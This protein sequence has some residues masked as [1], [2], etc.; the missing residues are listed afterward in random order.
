MILFLLSLLFL[1]LFL[2]M[3]LPQLLLQPHEEQQ[4]LFLLLWTD[5]QHIVIHLR[6]SSSTAAVQFFQGSQQSSSGS[7]GFHCHTSSKIFS[8]GSHTEHHWRCSALML[9]LQLPQLLYLL[10]PHEE[11]QHLFF[12]GSFEMIP[13]YSCSSQRKF[14]YCCC[15][16]CAIFQGSQQCSSGSTGFDSCTSSKTFSAGSHTKHHW[17]CSYA[18]VAAPHN[19]YFLQPPWR[20]T[21]FYFFWLLWNDP[22]I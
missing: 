6:G 14:Q 13:T 17:R 4:H 21:A 19:C 3:Q 20:A 8:A 10:Q 7:T 15:C 16:C 5:P 12:F 2:F 22:N 11:Q 18:F 9:L 1:F